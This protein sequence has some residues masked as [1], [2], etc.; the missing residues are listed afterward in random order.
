MSASEVPEDRNV[1]TGYDAN[2]DPLAVW[3][4][5]NK[6]MTEN[7]PEARRAVLVKTVPPLRRWCWAEI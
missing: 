6:N 5:M 1:F 2:I 7:L 4:T 3:K